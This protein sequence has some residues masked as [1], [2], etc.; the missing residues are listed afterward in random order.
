MILKSVLNIYLLS[1]ILSIST[2]SNAQWR[3]NDNDLFCPGGSYNNGNYC[4]R[5]PSGS[6]S[7]Y[8]SFRC[9]PCP[10]GQLSNSGRTRCRKRCGS[11]HFNNLKGRCRKCL[12]GT[13]S[14][15]SPIDNSVTSCTPCP[16]GQTSDYGAKSIGQCHACAPGGYLFWDSGGYGCEPCEEGEFNNDHSAEFCKLCPRGTTSKG[17]NV[18]VGDTNPCFLCPPGTYSPSIQESSRRVCLRC[19]P[20]WYSDTTGLARCKLCPAGSI[21]SEDRKACVPKDEDTT[22][23]PPGQEPKSLHPTLECQRCAPGFVS[24]VPSNT[25]CH[26]CPESFVPSTDRTNCVCPVGLYETNNGNRCTSCPENSPGQSDG[27]CQCPKEKIFNPDNYPPCT[28]AFGTKSD[29]SA[30]DNCVKCERR[31]LSTYKCDPCAENTVQDEA[32]QTCVSCPRGT[33]RKRGERMCSPCQLKHIANDGL[34]TCGCPLGQ[35]FVESVRMCKPCPIGQAGDSVRGGCKPC[36]D[37]F[38]SDEQGLP[39]CK[40]CPHGRRY[41]T[42]STGNTNCPPVCPRPNGFIKERKCVCK[43][44]FQKHE[45]NNTISCKRCPNGKTTDYRG[46]CVCPSGTESVQN[47]SK[48]CR[49]CRAGWYR[50]AQYGPSKCRKC[51]QNT[52]S[53]K[54]AER[55]ERCP[56]RLFSIGEGGTNCVRCRQGTFH[57]VDRKCGKCEPGFRVRKGKCVP[58]D[59]GS[60]SDGGDVSYCVPCENGKVPSHDRRSC[61]AAVGA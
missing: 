18:A 24:H 52:V 22:A 26:A 25:S 3:P 53:K 48:E 17:S 20:G 57:T 51:R 44:G 14:S 32:S 35:L 15:L 19:E 60:V 43:D 5:C 7:D 16:D 55:C 54:G 39:S 40:E 50:E 58:C 4:R 28:C 21:P 34:P 61:V 37:M 1:S 12:A 2:I 8:N 46:R 49:S 42:T 11:G 59:E 13:Y 10:A 9:T 31:E 33:L 27:I 36:Y 6:I 30:P 47:N 56:D 38:Y 45:A 29:E 41:R 23:C